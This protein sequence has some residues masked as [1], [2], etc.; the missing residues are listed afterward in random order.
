[1]QRMTLEELVVLLFLNT[2]RLCFLVPGAHV[3]GGRFAF[4]PGFGAFQNN[5]LSRHGLN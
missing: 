1:M 2:F 3:A 5:G 4:L